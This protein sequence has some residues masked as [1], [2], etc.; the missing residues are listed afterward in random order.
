[1]TPFPSLGKKL[2]LF[3]RTFFDINL[4]VDKIHIV[5]TYYFWDN[6]AGRKIHVV[7]TNF[8]RCNFDGQKTHV[9]WLIRFGSYHFGS[10]DWHLTIYKL[11]DNPTTWYFKNPKNT[12]LAGLK[13]LTKLCKK[14]FF[15]NIC[16]QC[17]RFA[18]KFML[19]RNMPLFL[20]C[21]MLFLLVL[22]KFLFHWF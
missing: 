5:S 8:Y 21:K 6:F 2:T 4:V 3:P 20:I 9:V 22:S 14:W 10:L 19:C 16:D 13:V 18:S 7:S 12:P 11:N 15:T 17:V 1:M